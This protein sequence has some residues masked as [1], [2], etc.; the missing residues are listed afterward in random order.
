MLFPIFL[1]SAAPSVDIIP[2]QRKQKPK[3]GHY[4]NARE[5]VACLYRKVSGKCRSYKCPKICCSFPIEVDFKFSNVVREL[6]RLLGVRQE[7]LAI[8]IYIDFAHCSLSL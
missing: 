8:L 7:N 4:I 3:A 2:A 5:I 1:P 6:K